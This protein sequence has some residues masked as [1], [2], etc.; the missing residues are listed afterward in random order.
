[1]TYKLEKILQDKY[2]F[3]TV[4]GLYCGYE[5]TGSPM[6]CQC[7]DGWY[8]IIDDLCA[9][10]SQIL[11]KEQQELLYIEQIKEKFGGLRF[12]YVGVDP[13]SI[14]KAVEDAM[15]ASLNTCEICGDKG[16][17]RTDRSWIQTLCDKHK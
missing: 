13:A 1:M 6:D 2:P 11:S 16:N 3:M 14:D 8:Q 15:E 5:P 12:Y 10:I 17:I 9:R 7:G 4:K